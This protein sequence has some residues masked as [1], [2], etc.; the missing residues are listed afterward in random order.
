[1]VTDNMAITSKRAIN[2][3]RFKTEVRKFWD[4]TDHRPIKWL[5]IF[6]IKRDHKSTTIL[7][8]QCTYI[9]SMLE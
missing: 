5:L 9:K 6:Q 4:I 2:A 1:M 7:I 8:N 3:E